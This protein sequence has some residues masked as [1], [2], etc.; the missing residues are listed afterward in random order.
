M[1]SLNTLSTLVLL[2]LSTL[3]FANEDGSKCVKNS[4]VPV[5]DY[6]LEASEAEVPSGLK[7]LKAKSAFVPV[8]EFVW[9]NPSDVP[10]DLNQ[11]PVPAYILEYEDE[12]APIEL[13]FVKA[14]S[15]FVPVAPFIT[16]DPAADAPS[17]IINK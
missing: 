16:G 11:V 7:F 3:S 13:A 12:P 5:T 14:K 10:S 15:A 17:E 6:I 9:G 2:L 1:K 4:S 8:A